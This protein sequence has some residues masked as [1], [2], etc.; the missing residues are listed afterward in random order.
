MTCVHISI[1]QNSF[2]VLKITLLSAYSFVSPSQMLAITDLLTVSIVLTFL[3]CHI[4]G[5]IQWLLLLIN[6]HLRF[7][8]SFSWLNNSF[9]FNVN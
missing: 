6:V 5:I 2:A 4:V 3:E 1:I 7:L 8:H 9:L